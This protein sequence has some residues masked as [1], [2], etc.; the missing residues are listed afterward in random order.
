MS[1]FAIWGVSEVICSKWRD[2]GDS[3]AFQASNWAGD[4]CSGMVVKTGASEY[5]ITTFILDVSNPEF[6]SELPGFDVKDEVIPDVV[7]ALEKW[8]TGIND[9]L[10][11]IPQGAW[12]K[13]PT[14]NTDLNFA[15]VS[16]LYEDLMKFGGRSAI[17]TLGSLLGIEESTAKERIRECRNRK[18][19]TSP[20]KG[21]RG[22]SS[23]TS[24][25]EK[26]LIEKGV[27]GA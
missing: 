25:A 27:L 18:F 4:S 1:N 15:I 21:V 12:P 22:T 8:N 3:A 23:S 14:A 6:W 5:T 10:S 13:G 20:G 11:W 24:R 2:I 26:L 9:L 7:V 17:R 16:Y 19:L